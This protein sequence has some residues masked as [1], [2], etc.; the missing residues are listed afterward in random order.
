MILSSNPSHSLFKKST[1]PNKFFHIQINQSSNKGENN[2]VAQK[3]KGYIQ[4]CLL[5][6]AAVALGQTGLG[7]LPDCAVREQTK[8]PFFLS[9]FFFPPSLLHTTQKKKPQRFVLQNNIFRKLVHPTF[10]KNAI[11]PI[12]NAIALALAGSKHSHAVSR[13]LAP[14]QI[15]QVSSYTFPSPSPGK[16]YR[17]LKPHLETIQVASNLCQLSVPSSSLPRK[18]SKAKERK[19]V[20]EGFH[21]GVNGDIL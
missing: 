7:D 18:C 16:S 8:P 6:L 14:M 5:A 9:F 4:T 20:G 3:M 13:T 2:A 15:K 1:L 11:W 19:R 17:K 10:Q 12:S 21:L